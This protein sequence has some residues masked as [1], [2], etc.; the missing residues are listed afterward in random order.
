MRRFG[1]VVLVAGS[2][3]WASGCSQT[4]KETSLVGRYFVRGATQSSTITQSS[5]EHLHSLN[6]VVDLDAKA[7]LEDI[8][9]FWQRDRGTRLS[10]WHER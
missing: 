3:L 5:S 2:I 1:I 8:D 7:L 6:G 4:A 10:R 9:A